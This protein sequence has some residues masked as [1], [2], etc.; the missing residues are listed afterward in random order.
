[1]TEPVSNATRNDRL[2]CD[3]DDEPSV[4]ESKPA[5]TKTA[6]GVGGD[7]SALR[8]AIDRNESR[9][10][11]FGAFGSASYDPASTYGDRDAAMGGARG[12]PG[13]AV[14]PDIADPTYEVACGEGRGAGVGIG[15][16]GGFALG[17]GPGLAGAVE[18]GVIFHE[19]G[20]SI[21]STDTKLPTHC[22]TPE[23][24]P[25]ACSTGVGATAGTGVAL[26]FFPDVDAAAG[27][28]RVAVMETPAGSAGLSCNEDDIT[29]YDV[30]VGP[31]VG[32]AM[33][34]THVTTKI[35]DVVRFG[36]ACEPTR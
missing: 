19:R 2:Y 23:G 10:R 16:N 5:K 31:S 12:G 29:S 4:C 8:E 13:G 11:N 27:D 6:S 25:D 17:A 28:G 21:Y 36:P 33:H 7:D 20:I 14:D 22:K 15:W 34:V 32:A 1:M 24:D 9:P 18:G 35:T 26:H 30:S 3:H